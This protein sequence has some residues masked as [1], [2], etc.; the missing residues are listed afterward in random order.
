VRLLGAGE[1]REMPGGSLHDSRAIE[2]DP[3]MLS[4]PFRV[5][6]SWHVIT[7]TVSCGKTTLI[8]Q[9]ANQ[10][11]QT[12][13]EIGR[14]YF[15]REIARG[16]TK[17]E[18]RE[19][20]AACQRA[21]VDMQ[22]RLECGLRATD[23]VFL[24]RGLPDCLAFCRV[25]GVNP[26]EILAECFRHRYACV[27]ALDRLPFQRDGLRD[28]DEAWAAFLDEWIAR[29]YRALGYKVVRVP[30]LPPHERVAFV[31]E[32]LAELSNH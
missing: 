16:R 9:L 29:D 22:L 24:D 25:T 6:T 12:V 2:L 31:L 26:N 17:D 5:Q 14:L 21:M 15:E 3:D 19:N 32:R 27:F 13:P 1:D 20:P 8:D 28:D 11:F 23:V 7:G 30:V 10:G 4:S 18:L